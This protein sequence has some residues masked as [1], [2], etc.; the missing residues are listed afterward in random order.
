MPAVPAAIAVTAP[1]SGNVNVQS[2]ISYTVVVW[3]GVEEERVRQY[4]VPEA[5]LT[6]QLK[7]YIQ[8]LRSTNSKT[9]RCTTMCPVS[10]DA[11]EGPDA[12]FPVETKQNWGV[13][14]PPH[15]RIVRSEL[16]N[17]HWD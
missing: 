7:E 1:A 16:V 6:R 9:E 12:V 13:P 17:V 2:C 5:M 11:I 14:V 8:H 4:I 10:H 15:V 3:G